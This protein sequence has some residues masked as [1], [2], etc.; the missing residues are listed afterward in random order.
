MKKLLREWIAL[1]YTTELIKESREK[2]AG[3]LM[4]TGIIQKAACPNQNHRIYPNEVLRREVQNY[5]KAVRERRAMGELDH[6]DSSTISLERVSHVIREMWWEGN[7][8]HGRI[9]VLPTPNGKILETLLE[10]GMTIGISSRG[11]GSVEKTNEGIDRVQP[12]FQLLCFD[13]VSEPSTPGAFLFAEGK[14][15][16]L[17]ESRKLFAKAD[18]IHR[19]LNDILSKR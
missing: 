4:L 3:K 5:D 13:I 14:D 15:I 6:P 9:E 10:S 18:R 17:D 19:A 7:D 1:P 2:N 16:S 12:D 11:V 8:V